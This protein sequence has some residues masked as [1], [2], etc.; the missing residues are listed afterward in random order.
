M[1][2]EDCNESWQKRFEI[3]ESID[4]NIFNIKKSTKLPYGRYLD[5]IYGIFIPTVYRGMCEAL[6]RDSMLE[7][8]RRGYAPCAAEIEP[9]GGAHLKSLHNPMVDT[10]SP[11]GKLIFGIF[12]VLAEYERAL[13]S[14]RTLD[15]LASA[16][17]TRSSQ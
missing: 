12:G 16:R 8:A 4:G 14:A 5:Y 3:L 1:K 6:A 10:T 7:S 11:N 15:G 9:T 17:A 13:I 2:R